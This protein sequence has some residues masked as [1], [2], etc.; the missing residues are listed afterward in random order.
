L[1]VI[2]NELNS[3]MSKWYLYF[4]IRHAECSQWFFAWPSAIYFFKLWW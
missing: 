4:K 2:K 3:N 1:C